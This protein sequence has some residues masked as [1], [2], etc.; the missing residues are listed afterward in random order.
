MKLSL[1]LSSFSFY[2]F[3]LPPLLSHRSWFLSHSLINILNTEFHLGICFLEKAYEYITTS[4]NSYGFFSTIGNL[5]CCDFSLRLQPDS[6]FSLCKMKCL[7]PSPDSATSSL[8]VHHKSQSSLSTFVLCPQPIKCSHMVSS[9]IPLSLVQSPNIFEQ[10]K[11]ALV[12]VCDT[13]PGIPIA[14]AHK[15]CTVHRTDK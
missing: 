7:P 4:K 5:L 14:S 12:S 1:I 9:N 10:H 15:L 6:L 11:E 2:P 3:I 8:S 13:C